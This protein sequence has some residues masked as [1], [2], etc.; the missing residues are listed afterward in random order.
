MSALDTADRWS[1]S[2]RALRVSD[3]AGS[4]HHTRSC[5]DSTEHR[6][7]CAQARSHL[8][9]CHASQSRLSLEPPQPGSG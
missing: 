6:I 1:L 5:E 8:S 9:T 2:Q 7:A 3:C 4:S